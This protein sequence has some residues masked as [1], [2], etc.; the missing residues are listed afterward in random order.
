MTEVAARAALIRGNYRY[1]LDRWLL[2]DFLAA[3]ERTLHVIGV[4]PSTADNTVDDA[5]VRKLLGFAS[6]LGAYR[7][8]VTNLFAYRATKVIALR[9]V[10]DPV[11]GG[12]TDYFMRTAFRDADINVAAWGPMAKLPWNLRDR[13]RHI[14]SLAAE[15]GRSLKCWG[16]AQDG[17]PRH[18]LMLSY[19]TP[20]VEWTPPNSPPQPP[21][22]PDV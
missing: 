14:V 2:G 19:D 3:N 22:Q 7:V 6:R 16:T 5:T 12:A 18:P 1:R 9:T 10:A 20:L 21:R 4:N 11:G 17:H 8:V 15:C 13:W